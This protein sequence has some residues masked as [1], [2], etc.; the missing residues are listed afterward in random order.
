MKRQF[1]SLLVMMIPLL[2]MAKEKPK[3]FMWYNDKEEQHMLEPE[4]KKEEKKPLTAT[5]RNAYIGKKFEEAVNIALDNP[6]IENVKR[7]REWQTLIMDKSQKFGEMWA[8]LGIS[9]MSMLKA[10]E[11]TNPLHK[12][13][14][15]EEKKAK[16]AEQLKLLSNQYGLI[17][18]LKPECKISHAFAPIIQDFAISHGFRVLAVSEEGNDFGIFQGSKDNGLIDGLNPN[19]EAPL[20]FLVDKDGQKIDLIARGI[21]PADEIGSNILAVTKEGR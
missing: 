19:K 14:Y 5:Q 18:Y 12:K 7:A 4:E 15:L 11:P 3:G 6:T 10:D 2:V 13:I 9:D 17:F 20:L 21:I 1:F 8:L 16:D